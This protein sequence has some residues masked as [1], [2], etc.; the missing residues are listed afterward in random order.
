M[1]RVLKRVL[2]SIKPDAVLVC[3]ALS[4]ASILLWLLVTAFHAEGSF[5]SSVHISSVALVA[6]LLFI[7][8]AAASLHVLHQGGFPYVERAM[9]ERVRDVLDFLTEGVLVLDLG[10]NVLMVN[11]A[12]LAIAPPDVPFELGSSARQLDWIWKS[13]KDIE[14]VDFPWESTKAA[15]R[16]IVGLPLEVNYRLARSR[17]FLVNCVGLQ[18]QHCKPSGYLITLDDISAVKVSD[19]EYVV[20]LAEL[21]TAR[22]VVGIQN[23]ELMSLASTDPLTSCLNRRAFV[24]KASEMLERGRVMRRPLTCVMCDIDKFKAFNDNFGHHTGDEVLKQV[25][26]LL[27]VTLRTGDLLCRYGGEEFCLLM[28][29]LTEENALA[30]CERLRRAIE[31]NA[32]K[33]INSVKGLTVTMSLG[34]CIHTPSSTEDLSMMVTRADA[35]LYEAKNAGRNRVMLFQAAAEPAHLE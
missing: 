3:L 28:V 11:K 16:A 7:L 32:G 14:N 18:D 23:R 5:F 35:A 22:D 33:G 21:K 25:A 31:L 9:P 6:A 26:E 8:A 1:Q 2:K 30:L 17:R 27:R 29:D 20:A 13:L 12:F 15:G 34:V 4:A 10:G 19:S 24:S